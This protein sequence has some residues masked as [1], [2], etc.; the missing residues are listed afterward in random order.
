[1]ELRYGI[2]SFFGCALVVL[3]DVPAWAQTPTLSSL[4]PPLGTERSL[5]LIEGGGLSAAD[6]V[7]DAGL[8]SEKKL[9]RSVQGATMFSV[10]PHSTVGSHPIAIESP[11][12]RSPPLSFVVKGGISSAAPRLDGVSL[13]NV[14]FEDEG[15][16]RV[17]LYVQGANFDVGARVLVDDVEISSGAHKAIYNNLF[18]ANPDT[19]GYPV[20]HY[21]SRIVSEISRPR[22]SSVVVK[23]VNEGGENS[24]EMIYTV[25]DHPNTVSSAGDGIADEE[26]RS[27][28][29]NGHGK[30]DLKALGADPYRKIVFVQVD[31]MANVKRPIE[32]SKDVR[33]TFDTVRQMFAN[34]PVLNPYG[35]NGIDLVIDATGSVPQWSYLDFID[36]DNPKTSTGSFWKMKKEHLDAKRVGLYHYAVWG[37]ERLDGASGYSDVDFDGT[38]VGDAFMITMADAPTTYQ[39]I[40]SQAETFAHELGHDLGQKHGGTNHSR[41]KPNYWSVMSY[42]WQLR[43]SRD[44]GTRL[45]YPT[46]TQIYYATVGAMERNGQLP[47]QRNA[48]IDYSEGMGPSLVG[49]TNSLNETLGVCGQPIDWNKN[50]RI[51]AAPVSAQIDD[52]DVVGARV[53]DMANWPSLRFDG[54]KLGGSHNP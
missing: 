53:E 6:V 52:D 38:K 19:L 42:T 36:A 15:K 43:S 14:S 45:K 29:D 30:L 8:I 44:D 35:P 3:L 18:G 25:P 23:V 4:Q 27:G 26:K 13:A 39:T 16:A 7:W 22:G 11:A 51:D 41:H 37:R 1:M 10:P 21:L 34:A 20:R 28:Y 33:G 50:G 9:P 40:Q 49:N 46:C 2:D 24:N 47:K 5:V 17:T 48:R 31:I 32:T 54:P 12:G